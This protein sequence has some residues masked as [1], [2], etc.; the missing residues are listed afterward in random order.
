MIFE[1]FFALERICNYSFSKLAN[2]ENQADWHTGLGKRN[3][4]KLAY[5]TGSSS[6]ATLLHGYFGNCGMENFGFPSPHPSQVL[7]I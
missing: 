6:N 3:I 7:T 1:H 5:F 2:V 4:A